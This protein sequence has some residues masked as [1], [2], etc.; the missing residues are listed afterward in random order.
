MSKPIDVEIVREKAELT[1]KKALPVQPRFF[2]CK[3]NRVG[4]SAGEWVQCTLLQDLMGEL[5]PLRFTISKNASDC[6]HT[7]NDYYE[8]PRY[9]KTTLDR[10]YET[11][12]TLIIN[13]HEYD[14]SHQMHDFRKALAPAAPTPRLTHD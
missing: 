6:A 14:I 5:S 4:G 1:D 11:V 2:L 8:S 13:G 9:D 7:F 12:R 3:G 10:V